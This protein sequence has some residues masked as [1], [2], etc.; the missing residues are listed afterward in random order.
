MEPR[1]LKILLDRTK[2]EINDFAVKKRFA[3]FEAIEQEGLELSAMQLM[4]ALQ[5]LLPPRGKSTTIKCPH[6][7]NDL[8]VT[9]T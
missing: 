5:V 9:I 7:G 3:S 8:S 4:Q 6:C 2:N 1:E